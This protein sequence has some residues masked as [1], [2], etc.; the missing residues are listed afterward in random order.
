M[1]KQE[2]KNWI[3]ILNDL[4]GEYYKQY[5]KDKEKPNYY[6][7][8]PNENGLFA[9][10]CDE[11]GFEESSMVYEEFKGEDGNTIPV[12]EFD[13]NQFL[14]AD[15]DE[16]DN[17]PFDDDNDNDK[18]DDEKAEIRRK[19]KI[20]KLLIYIIE[21]EELPKEVKIIKSKRLKIDLDINQSEVQRITEEIFKKQL[22]CLAQLG[23]NEPDLMYYLAVGHKN[24]IPFLTWLIDAYTLDKT[25]HYVETEKSLILEDWIAKNQFMKDLKQHNSKQLNKLKTAMISYSNRILPRLQFTPP[26]KVN[27]DIKVIADYVSM[28]PN[29]IKQ[30]MN[31]KQNQASPPFCV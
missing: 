7:T 2:E 25:K 31:N 26:T 30:L 9:Y 22:T 18:N 29:V 24:G 16:N 12:T 1:A 14:L 3:K 10:F 4:L 15:F 5:F 17:S 28:I 11:N 8:K 21:N 23:T 27:D 13:P 20:Y 6:Y 19:K